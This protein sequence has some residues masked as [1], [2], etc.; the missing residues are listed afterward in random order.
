MLV[1]DDE[2]DVFLME[3][4]L[5]KANIPPP[6][7][8][9]TDGRQAL[10]YLG[11]VGRFADRATHPLPECLFL[12]LK[13]PFVH[14]FEVL[15]WIRNQPEL[16]G[17]NVFVLTSSPEERDHRKA[18]DLGAKKYLIK[19]PTAEMLQEMMNTFPRCFPS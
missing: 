12:D 17:L 14:G 7:Q 16:A 10:D 1:E 18:L 15:E 9:L 19:P 2:N 6:M 8:V 4:A 13:L 11:G 5:A 3:R